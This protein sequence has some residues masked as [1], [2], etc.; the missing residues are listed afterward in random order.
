MTTQAAPKNSALGET[1]ATAIGRTHR[2]DPV[3][4]TTGGPAGNARLTA[5]IGLVLLVLFVVECATLISLSGLT[6]V[7]I[8]LGAFLVPLVLLKTATTGWRMFRYYTGSEK[9]LESGPPPL[10]LRVLGPLVVLGALAVLGTGLSLVA[11]GQAASRHNAFTLVG[12]GVSAVT[13]HQ[14]AFVLW[15]SSTALHLLGRFVPALQ[16]SRLLPATGAVPR[17]IPGTP[18]RLTVA[19]L[20]VAVAVATGALVLSFSGSWTSGPWR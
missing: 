11:L 17:D 1:L 19:A 20:T 16:L 14:A 5:W 10:P 8:F 18:G 3:S 13:L 7:H 15:I 9:Y 12:F 4:P 2:R 6:A